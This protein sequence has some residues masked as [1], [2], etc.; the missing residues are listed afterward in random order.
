MNA[1]KRLCWRL[2]SPA[3]VLAIAVSA[4]SLPVTRSEFLKLTG[5]KPSSKIA[6]AQCTLCHSEGTKLNP[7]GLDLQKA[8]RAEKTRKL[9]AAVLKRVAAL[10]SD[11]DKAGNEKEWKSDTLPGDPKS[12]PAK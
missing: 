6:S 7:F 10:D 8:M 12:K 5:L 3:A 11:K 4:A 9:T 1:S 2:F